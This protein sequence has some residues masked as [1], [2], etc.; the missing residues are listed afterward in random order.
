MGSGGT[1]TVSHPAGTQTRPS[2][3]T[4]VTM[5][6]SQKVLRPTGPEGLKLFYFCLISDTFCLM[7]PNK[8]LHL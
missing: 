5:G 1:D 6:C 4:A 8:E 3:L 2:P 7:K